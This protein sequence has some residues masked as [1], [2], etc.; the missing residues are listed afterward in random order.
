MHRPMTERELE[1]LANLVNYNE[2]DEERDFEEQVRM[3][4]FEADKPKGHIVH[5]IRMLDAF[6][7]DQ[8][9]DEHHFDVVVTGCSRTE[10]DT[11]IAERTGH[12]EDYG[13]NYQI[14]VREES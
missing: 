10:A 2:Q 5:D 3:G 1:A 8:K 7:R 4:E 12:D 9:N 6:L 13:F 11:V 14:E